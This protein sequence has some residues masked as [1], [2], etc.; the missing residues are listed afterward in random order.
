MMK[1]FALFGA[2]VFFAAMAGGQ[3]PSQVR[4]VPRVDL[5][6]YAGDWYEVARL[7]NRFQRR[8]RYGKMDGS[9]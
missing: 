2:V 3:E 8:M 4:V 1:T 5:A 7:P 6:R 9:T